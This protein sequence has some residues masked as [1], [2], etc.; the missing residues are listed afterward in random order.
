MSKELEMILDIS[1]RAGQWERD[2]PQSYNLA[3]LSA[4]YEQRYQPTRES[5]DSERQQGT[6]QPNA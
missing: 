6:Q 2:E 3:A 1:A 4:E 5:Q